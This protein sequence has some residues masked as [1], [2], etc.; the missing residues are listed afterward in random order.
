LD[1][2]DVSDCKSSDDEDGDVNNDDGD[3][4]SQVDDSRTK[5][6]PQVSEET[7][8]RNCD[9]SATLNDA[10]NLVDVLNTSVEAQ[11]CA[12]NQYKIVGDNI[13]KNI[14]PSFQ[15]LDHQTVRPDCNG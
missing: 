10:A 15:Q 5:D 13:D 3:H 8:A 2:A 4:N 14:R 1:T 7:D 11:P 9:F 6:L 12:S